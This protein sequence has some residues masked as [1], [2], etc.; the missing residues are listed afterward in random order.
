MNKSTINQ[1]LLTI[2]VALVTSIAI[3]NGPVRGPVLWITLLALAPA[4]YYTLELARELLEDY[5]GE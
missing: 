5:E 3:F 2:Q 1:I 4:L